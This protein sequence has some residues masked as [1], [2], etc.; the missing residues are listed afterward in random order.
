MPPVAAA[1]YRSVDGRCSLTPFFPRLLLAIIA[2]RFAFNALL[3][4]PTQ[5]LAERRGTDAHHKDGRRLL[6]ESWV[7]LGNTLML[8]AALFVVL[9]RCGWGEVGMG[10]GADGACCR[11]GC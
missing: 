1:A 2:A 6:E 9:R 10:G 3:R 8:G 5:R 7:L 4:G 11:A